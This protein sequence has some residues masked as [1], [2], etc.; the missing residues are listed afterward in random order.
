MSFIKLALDFEEH[1]EH[2]LLAAKFQG[3][4]LPRQERAKVLRLTLCTLQ[5][6][7]KTG[8]L[9]PAK[10]ITRATSLVPLGGLLV[11]GLNRRLYF[12]CRGAMQTHIQHLSSYTE[13]TWALHTHTRTNTHRPYV[14][15]HPQSGQEVE[16]ARLQ[17]ALTRPAN[18]AGDSYPIRGG[19]GESPRPPTKSHADELW[20]RQLR[21]H[22]W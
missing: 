18:F 22:A 11:A 6:L 20:G 3:H 4:T 5:M 8:S 19:G 21:P 17:R 1:T 12:A 7:V 16:E 14:Y 13:S 9:R 15:C 2:T 10:V